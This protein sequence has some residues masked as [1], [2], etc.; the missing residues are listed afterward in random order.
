MNNNRKIFDS[1]K[2][3]LLPNS[4]RQSLKI[5]SYPKR[6]L[7]LPNQLFLSQLPVLHLRQVFSSVFLGASNRKH[8]L[9]D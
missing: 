2:L 3:K 8:V 9:K 6:L 7:Q 1:I 5:K 4:L